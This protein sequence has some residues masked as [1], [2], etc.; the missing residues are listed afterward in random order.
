MIPLLKKIAPLLA[1]LS[2]RETVFLLAGGAF[3]VS[4]LV[5]LFLIEPIREQTVLSSRLIPQKEEEILKL[6]RL[7]EKYVALSA[8]MKEIE[9]RLPG[10]N[11]FSLL[12]YLE[13]IAKQNQ[14][15]E[16]ISSIRAIPPV[17]QAPYREIPMEVKMENISLLRIIPFL[18]TIEN[19]P[20]FLRIKRLS[21]KTRVSE[22]QK[23]DVTFV[24]SS[25]EKT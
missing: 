10:A 12:S 1:K 18:N 22:P 23:L 6:R 4:L 25:Y 20:Y 9:G 7:S 17:T 2:K 16:N 14:V 21:I 8:R 11:Q 5:Y 24:V 13:K 19:A 15:R 3:T